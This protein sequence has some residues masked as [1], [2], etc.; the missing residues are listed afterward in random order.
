MNVPMIPCKSRI[1]IGWDLL[2]VIA[3][4]ISGLAI[5]YR[6]LSGRDPADFLYWLI[7]VIFCLDILIT[8]NTE[9]KMGLNILADR[10]SVAKRYLGSWFLPDLLAALPL[11]PLVSLIMQHDASGTLV[12]QIVSLFRLLRL[13]KLVKISTTFSALEDL[14]NI[15]PALIRLIIFFFWFA[16]IAHF[17]ALGWIA[18]GAGESGRSFQDQ[19]IRALYWCTTTIATIGYGD[20]T[21]NRDSNLQIIYTIIVQIIGVGMFGYIIGNVATL[22]VNIDSA[23]ADYRNRMEE[24][25]N[26][27]RINKIPAP[28]Q[29]RVKSYY[30]Y[31][32]ETRQ[33]VTSIDFK[34][35][36]PK[37]LQ[38]EIS[39]FLNREILEKV[40]LFK[41]ADEIFIH[42]VIEELEPL[43]FL[44][45]D[46]IIRQGEWGDCMY[47]LSKGNVEVIVNE[48]QV[49]T[50]AEGSPF[51]ETAL[52]ENEER[53]ASIRAVTFCDVYRLSQQSFDHL[54]KKHPEFD[55]RVKEI[56]LQRQKG[57]EDKT[58][59]P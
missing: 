54:R 57:Q 29:D 28:L 27:M 8:F 16:L 37:T 40:S 39:L 55:K 22:I 15:P 23:R 11:A 34:S 24:V 30:H 44:P 6:M 45:G 38:L 51:G 26:Y 47:F 19:Y 14:I 53:N 50:L 20:Y 5:P 1:K 33:A 31:L 10:K 36:L 7:T 21:P 4:F 25:R 2:L 46:F 59:Q 42:E 17:I 41:N 58:S 56:S 12:Y 48:K 35:R 32:W 3:V 52:I 13:L 18:I 43:V 49:A 9:V